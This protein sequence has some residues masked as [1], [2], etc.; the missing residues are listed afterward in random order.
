MLQTLSS[1]QL[2]SLTY[3][4][5]LLV[6]VVSYSLVS[7]RGRILQSLRQI[8]LW[9]LIIVGVAA[10]YNLWQGAGLSMAAMQQSTDGRS[11]ALRRGFDGQYHLAMMIRGPS[12]VE[13]AINF[14]VD[15]G[16]TDMVLTTQDAEKLGFGP[17]GLR[18]LG[19]ARTANGTTRT[20]LVQLDRVRLGTMSAACAPRER[21][22]SSCLVAGHAVS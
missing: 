5:I 4:T 3:L 20:A 12:G 16:A 17:D 14:I 22:R 10:G 21:G 7:R 1:D 2:Q 19:T 15:T 8:V 11:M 6:V 9:G 13:Q 18:F